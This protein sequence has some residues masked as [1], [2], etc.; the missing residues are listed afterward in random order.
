MCILTIG[1]LAAAAMQGSAIRASTVAYDRTE[2]NTIATTLLETLQTVDFDH[3]LL[4]EEP[5]SAN[6]LVYHIPDLAQ[7]EKTCRFTN[8]TEAMKREWYKQCES[9][10]CHAYTDKGK[11]PAMMDN[12][13]TVVKPDSGLVRDKSGLMYVLYWWVQDVKVKEQG[14]D[15]TANK[16]I[17]V[18]LEWNTP[19]GKNHLAYTTT[20]YLNVSL[21][22]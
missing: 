15:K 11:L 5:D 6:K 17:H 8:L 22:K 10:K 21:K 18:F 1:V 4:K 14:K 3:E 16:N 7:P 2:A 13:V 9:E 19:Y 20:K 12:L